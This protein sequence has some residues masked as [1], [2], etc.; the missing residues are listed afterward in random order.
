MTGGIAAVAA[1]GVTTANQLIRLTA[2]VYKLSTGLAT[3]E[4]T[5]WANTP[6]GNVTTPTASDGGGIDPTGAL[7]WTATH[8][9]KC[10][11]QDN[12]GG[13]V[14]FVGMSVRAL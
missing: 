5:S 4:M 9:I 7:D 10:A 1:S 6:S 13:P 14:N 8:L 11:S 2:K 12:G 3:S